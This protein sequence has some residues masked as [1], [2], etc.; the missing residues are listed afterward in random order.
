MGMVVYLRRASADE[1]ARL[2]QEPGSIDEVLFSE[3]SSD[4]LIDFDKAWHALHFMLT[5]ESGVAAHPLN[6]LVASEEELRGADEMGFGGYW[7]AEPGDVHRFAASLS[8]LSDEA[9]ASK[10]DPAAMSTEHVYLSDVFEEEGA[11]A[12]PYILQGLPRLRALAAKASHN[13]D[14][15]IGALR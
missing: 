8:E 3:G 14:Y 5:G 12:L 7:L 6:L 4:R 9:I 2:D 15:I 10:Y 1:V 13:N 11:E